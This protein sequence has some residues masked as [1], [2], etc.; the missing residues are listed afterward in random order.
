MP[1]DSV[2]DVFRVSCQSQ[3]SRSECQ[4]LPKYAYDTAEVG[5]LF[6]GHSDWADVVESRAIQL[7]Q[8]IQQLASDQ[9]SVPMFSA[10]ELQ[11]S[12]EQ[13][14]NISK[15]LPFIAAKRR[16][17]RRERHG[18]DSKTLRL[19]SQ[20]NKL[21]V[22]DDVLYRVTKDLVSKQKRLQYVLPQTLKGKA[23]SG[24]HDLAGHQGQDRTLSLA[25][26]R[27]Y[28]PDM[29]KDIRTYVRHCQRCVLGKSPEPAARA[30]LENIISTTP[31]ELVC[32]DFWSAEDCKQRLVDVLVI[33]DH[34]TKLAHAF[35]CT[36]QTA[37]Q[38]AKKLWDNV[39]CIY[40]FPQRIHSDQ[41]TNFESNLIAELLQLAG[42]A[43]SHTTAYHPMGNGGTERFNCTLGN[44]L[45]TLPLGVK[46][47]WPEQ[48]QT[49]TFAYN[50]TVH[51]TTGY[52]PFFSHVWTHPKTASR[53]H[54][55]AGLD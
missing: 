4:P 7:V 23:L 2:Q 6:Q 35:P 24:I 32:I 1:E 27:F 30:P 41:G 5:A 54:V 28:W 44:M 48:I 29:E 50:C 11:Q 34:F 19:F 20:W 26:Q 25:R 40:G 9:T 31:M 53:H 17:S 10:Q 33:T 46:H 8:H 47:Q 38:V 21:E 36:N 42:V 55:Q 51:E 13:D 14:P 52:A 49:L 12:Q 45:R 15:V 43:K 37:K 16:P 22:H 39:F 3:T 18:A